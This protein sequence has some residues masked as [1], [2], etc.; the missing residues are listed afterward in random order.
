MVSRRQLCFLRFIV[1]WFPSSVYQKLAT[2]RS[3]ICLYNILW[4]LKGDKMK[5]SN[6]SLCFNLGYLGP[7]KRWNTLIL[8][9]S[10]LS[11]FLH[12]LTLHSSLM[13][14][15]DAGVSTGGRT[16]VQVELDIF[17][18]PEAL[19]VFTPGE[20][21]CLLLLF[22]V[23]GDTY[24]KWRDMPHRTPACRLS[25]QFFSVVNTQKA[26]HLAQCCTMFTSYTNCSTQF[27]L[28]FQN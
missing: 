6:S 17:L 26:K 8:N 19:S 5:P 13:G 11:T 9:K 2:W 27:G 20:D 12:L 4:E 15:K 28:T 3:S 14:R 18:Q 16:D 22:V 1:D 7:W 24:V 21:R 10:S 25:L 23:T